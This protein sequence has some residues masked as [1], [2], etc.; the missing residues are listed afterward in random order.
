MK[1]VVASDSFKGSLSSEKIIELL[2]ESAEKVFNQ[3]Y[4]D[5]IVTADGGEGTI[6]AVLSEVSWKRRNLLVKGP[7]FEDVSSYYAIINNK[8][9]LI[10][11]AKASGLPMVEE[12]KRNPYYT[13]SYGVGMLVEDALNLGIK[14]I[15]IAIGGSA[16]NDG[17]IGAMSALGIKFLDKDKNVLK[18]RGIDLKEIYDIDLTDMDKRIIYAHFTVMCDVKNPLLGENGATY[19]FGRQK[20]AD[21][22]ILKGLEYGMKNYAYIVYKK[23]GKDFTYKEGAGAAGGLGYALMTFLNA[24]LKSGIETVLDIVNFDQKIKDADLVI[25]GEGR[26]DSQSAYGKVVSGVGL[27]CRKYNIPCDAIVGSV[28]DGY[29]SIYTC[30]INT[31][32]TTVNGIMSLDEALK[33]A[34]KLYLDASFRL[35][36]AVKSGMEMKNK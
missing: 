6:E 30:G 31:V 8:T 34:E 23:T 12:D 20:G 28:L 2:K 9:A 19:T 22:D 1:I 33:N 29:E 26:M 18:G 27:R 24:D 21:D 15:V 35:L 17:G 16:T 14:D 25:T 3:V 11:M 32:M 36:S 4:I 5:G 7:L 13:T 10:E